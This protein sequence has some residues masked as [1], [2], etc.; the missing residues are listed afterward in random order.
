M[1]VCVCVRVRV[2]VCVCVCVRVC[3]CV[4]V[5]VCVCVRAR[6]CV[7]LCVCACVCVREREREREGSLCVTIPFIQGEDCVY[8][9]FVSDQQWMLSAGRGY[10]RMT[11]IILERRR[12]S[13][14]VCL[15]GRH[16]LDLF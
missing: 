1:C 13:N 12:I 7:C 14:I 2:C 9:N 11:C 3:M 16:N 5:R 8:R 4:C 10:E 6:A 15:H